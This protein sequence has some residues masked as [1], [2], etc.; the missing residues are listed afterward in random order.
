MAALVSDSPKIFRTI[1]LERCWC[2]PLRT[3]SNKTKDERKNE[4]NN[5]QSDETVKI[6]DKVGIFLDEMVLM[7][8]FFFR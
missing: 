3:Q 5:R 6:K 1:Q 7:R 2:E 4:N 8:G